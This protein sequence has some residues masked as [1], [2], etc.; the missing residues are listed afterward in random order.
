M[1][2]LLHLVKGEMVRL[3]KYRII[4]FGLLVSVIWVG[5]IAFVD[6]TTARGFLPFL[7][8]MDAGMMSIILLAA[9]FYL[10]KQESTIKTLL[11]SPVSLAEVLI[12]KVI[13]A[14]MT[15]MISVILVLGSGYLIHGIETNPF[16]VI[17]YVIV[18]VTA[19]TAIGYWVTLRSRDF[20]SMVMKYM[21]FALLFMLPSLFF[22]LGVVEESA[23]L[24]LLISPMY[25]SEFLIKSV[26]GNAEPLEVLLACVYLAILGLVI[27]WKV[28]YPRFQRFAIGG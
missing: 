20:G 1:N 8:M 25:A 3:V 4:F 17:L 7:A 9:S 18:I 24:F 15:A 21:G 16:L 6:E 26:V 22:Y 12:A 19:N 23:Q 2:N 28:V 27:Y 14:I 11:V 10:E 5:V 13:S